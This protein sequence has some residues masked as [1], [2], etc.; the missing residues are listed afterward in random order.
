MANSPSTAASSDQQAGATAVGGTTSKKGFGKLPLSLLL[1]LV[2]LVVIGALIA[3]LSDRDGKS[4]NGGTVI[5]S[6]I[7]LVGKDAPTGGAVHKF[8]NQAAVGDQAR[9]VQLAGEKAKGDNG[10]IVNDDERFFVGSDAHQILVVVGNGT[11]L[12]QALPPGHR[13]SFK[14]TV[15]PYN[16]DPKSIGIDPALSDKVKAEGSYIEVDPATVQVQA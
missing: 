9:I 14:G 2:A 15:K 4:T 5:S 16:G 3:L 1:L 6:G 13:I 8:D 11:E 10:Q 12:P 7:D